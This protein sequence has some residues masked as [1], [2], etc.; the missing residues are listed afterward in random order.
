MRSRATHLNFAHWNGILYIGDSLCGHRDESWLGLI[1]AVPGLLC[2]TV[3][4][5]K[6]ALHDLLAASRALCRCTHIT[7]RHAIIE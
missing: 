5:H 1:L 2:Q 6:I 3:Q 7:E 4:L